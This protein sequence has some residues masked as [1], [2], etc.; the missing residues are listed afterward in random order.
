LKELFT[1]QILWTAIAANAAAQIMKAVLVLIS[2]RKW[3]SDRLF[4]SGGMPSSHAALVTALATGIALDQ[5]LSSP[6]FAVSMVFALIV[7]HDA[8]GVRQAAGKHAHI[9]NQLTAEL[10][11]LFE[12]G[13]KPEVLKTFLGHSCL[14][15]LAGIILGLGVALFS[16]LVWPG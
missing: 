6:L 2:E 7:M 10:H 11:Q 5:G 3:R 15:V 8:C 1:N 12:E 16:Y 13:L 14:Q 9:L 4:G